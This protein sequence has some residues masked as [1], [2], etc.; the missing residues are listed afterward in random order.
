ML[1]VGALFRLGAR[2]AQSGNDAGM[3]P[4]VRMILQVVT[5]SFLV[6]DVLGVMISVALL[7]QQDWARKTIVGGSGLAAL[8]VTVLFSHSKFLE[9]A[10]APTPLP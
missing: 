2:A 6:A 5:Y 4:Q 7:A 10:S 8:L 3:T 1:I 9:A